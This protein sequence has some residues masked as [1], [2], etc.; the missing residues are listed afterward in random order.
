VTRDVAGFRRASL[1]VFEAHELLSA[2][3]AAGD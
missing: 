3:I 1:P 2:L